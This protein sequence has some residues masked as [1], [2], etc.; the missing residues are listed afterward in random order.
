MRS[1]IS[2]KFILQYVS[3]YASPR[4]VWYGIGETRKQILEGLKYNEVQYGDNQ[5]MCNLKGDI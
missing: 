3:V 2:S 5:G 1:G 4:C